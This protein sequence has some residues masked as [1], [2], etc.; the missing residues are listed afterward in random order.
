MPP[1]V[2]FTHDTELLASVI[3]SMPEQD[4]LPFSEAS[5]ACPIK[6][7][8]LFTLSSCCSFPSHYLQLL[9]IYYCLPMNLWEG[10]IFSHI[11][12][13]VWGGGW[14]LPMMHWTSS[15]R[16]SA[17]HGTSLY[18]DTPKTCSNLFNLKPH[19][20]GTPTPCW[21]QLRDMFKLFLIMKHMRLTSWSFVSYWNAFLLILDLLAC[22]P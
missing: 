21:T 6:N 14:P 18:R 19:C 1:S 3:E 16:N 11:C 12:H 17:R 4:P 7:S 9:H 22:S 5:H 20:T 8:I 13:S 15:L 2:K 10:N